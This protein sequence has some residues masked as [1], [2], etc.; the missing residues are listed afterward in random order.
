[1]NR[2]LKKFQKSPQTGGATLRESGKHSHRRKEGKKGQVEKSLLLFNPSV[3]SDSLR[4]MDCSV[5][6]FPALRHLLELAHTHA[7]R[8]SDT[9]QPSHPLRPPPP[10]ALC[11]FP[12]QEFR[13][14]LKPT[15]KLCLGLAAYAVSSPLTPVLSS[16]EFILISQKSSSSSFM[17]LAYLGYKRPWF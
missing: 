10:P 2:P 3:V 14:N 6:G 11:L 13:V 17:P 4:P 9:I 7:H 1:M 5:P 16:S 15:P 12:H 8:V